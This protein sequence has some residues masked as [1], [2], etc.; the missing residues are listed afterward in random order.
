MVSTSCQLYLHL[1]PVSYRPSPVWSIAR[2]ALYFFP[3]H[4][5]Y[6]WMNIIMTVLGRHVRNGRKQTTCECFNGIQE[7]GERK[8]WRMLKS[9]SGRNWQTRCSNAN[10]ISLRW[11]LFMYINGLDLRLKNVNLCGCLS[12]ILKMPELRR[13]LYQCTQVFSV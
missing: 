4:I 6:N 1:R 9:H 7:V 13:M 2:A 11:A 8:R 3:I 10:V 12:Y 5:M